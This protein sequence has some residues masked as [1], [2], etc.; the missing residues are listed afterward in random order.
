MITATVSRL[1]LAM[2]VNGLPVPSDFLTY[3]NG[4]TFPPTSTLTTSLKIV[5]IESPDGRTAMANKISIGLRF[6]V[7]G[8]PTDSAILL[9]R[10]KL[11][12]YGGVFIYGGRGVGPLSINTGKVKDVMYG[13]KPSVLSI[14]PLGYRNA[15]SIDW[16]VTLIVPECSD[17]RYAFS[18][19]ALSYSV[20]F[21]IRRDGRTNRS[22]TGELVI[23]NNRITP[24]SSF[25]ADNPDSYREQIAPIIG[26]GFRREWGTFRIDPSR[27]KLAF[28]WID[29]EFGRNIYPP[30]IVDCEVTQ[31]VRTSTTGPAM[32]L[33]AAV[34]SATY[35]LAADCSPNVAKDHFFNVIL[36]DR[37]YNRQKKF[38]STGGRGAGAGVRPQPVVFIPQS[39]EASD[40]NIYGE[41]T[42]CHFS[43]G[44]NIVNS[45][46]ADILR[47]SGMWEIVTKKR[48]EE[49]K[50]WA[51]SLSGSALNPRGYSK[52]EFNLRDDEIIDLCKGQPVVET[53]SGGRGDTR[54][55][56]S[57]PLFDPPTPDSSWLD[58]K[59]SIRVESLTGT[60]SSLPLYSGGTPP[61]TKSTPTTELKT[62]N[63]QLG[64]TNFGSAESTSTG[65]GDFEHVGGEPAKKA[66]EP[67][68]TTRTGPT[69]YVYMTG[70]AMRAGFAIPCPEL[71]KIDGVTVR[72][73]NRLDKGEGFSTG[74][75]KQTSVPIVGAK[76]NLRY[77]LSSMPKNGIPVPP[78]P[79]G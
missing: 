46:L 22:I 13:P 62:P 24:G 47:H 41:E 37:V 75:F 69:I 54:D 51:L 29:K 21:Q 70:H 14:K 64:P 61:T 60:V 27:T 15:C 5:P 72:L 12:K 58:Y 65:K 11:T 1:L 48:P 17:A 31:N 71:T 68:N 40:R 57:M 42:Q 23:P 36:L 7:T 35:T 74:I 67:N 8:L 34:L 53:G 44:Y 30:G 6:E 73:A 18:P 50:T 25:S 45:S 77:E 76:W 10:Q 38:T 9:L 63:L 52:L 59:N 55:L 78:D 2:S 28:G 33:F 66:D 79:T 32:K 19:M 3:Y 4:V 49:W 43:F 16:E 56:T 26:E 39:F 20:E